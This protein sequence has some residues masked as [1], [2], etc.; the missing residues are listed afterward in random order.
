MS[1]E[2]QLL[3]YEAIINNP[4]FEYENEDIEDRDEQIENLKFRNKNI[5]QEDIEIE[6]DFNKDRYEHLYNHLW[7]KIFKN[8]KR[9]NQGTLKARF[10]NI[11]V[12]VL[13]MSK[14]Y[15]RNMARN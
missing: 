6:V 4:M 5:S 13:E 12:G 1:I 8:C 9:I 3:I 15:T 10:G 14:N 2:D 7:E 11:F